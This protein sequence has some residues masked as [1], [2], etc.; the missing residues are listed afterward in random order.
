[1]AEVHNEPNRAVTLRVC[2]NW[3]DVVDC[4]GGVFKGACCVTSGKLLGNSF[5]DFRSVVNGRLVVFGES[6]GEGTSVPDVKSRLKT[7]E[8]ASN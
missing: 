1:M 8:N 5:G 7:I 3:G 2:T 4:E 6:V